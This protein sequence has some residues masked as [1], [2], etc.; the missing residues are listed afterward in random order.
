LSAQ[1][2]STKPKARSQAQRRAA[3]RAA[4]LEATARG[5]SRNGYANLRLEVVAVE[6][7]YS[8]GALY[9]Q[10]RGKDELVLAALDWVRDRWY[11]EVATSISADLPPRDTLI[12]LARRHAVFC[13]RDIAG[14]MTA[15]RVEFA[16]QDHPVA[17]AVNDQTGAVASLISELILRG[18]QDGTLPDGPPARTLADAALAA[19]EAAVIATAA[20]QANAATIAELIAAGLLAPRRRL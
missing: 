4:L 19:V 20:D 13:R 3:S 11:A 6:A 5:L 7:G 10:F 12:E 8:R 1:G 17:Q 16:G 2:R 15:L 14:V 18:R 9:H